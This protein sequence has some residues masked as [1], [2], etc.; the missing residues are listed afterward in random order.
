MRAVRKTTLLLLS[1]MLLVLAVAL[2]GCESHLTNEEGEHKTSLPFTI[3]KAD[4]FGVIDAKSWAT[5]FPNQYRTYMDNAKNK[6]PEGKADLL[7][8]YPEMVVN[9][10]GY[11]Y[12]KFFSEAGGHTY[13]LYTVTHNGRVGAKTKTGCIACKTPQFN[14]EAA[15]KGSK[16]YKEAFWPVVK[17]Y[18][19]PISCANC[20]DNEWPGKL[21]ITREQ[22]K[23]ALGDDADQ[24]TLSGEVCGQCHCDY[25]MDPYTAEPTS[26]YNG[27]STMTPD[28]ALAWYDQR[29]YTDWV[30]PSTGAKMIAVRHS[31]YEYNYGGKGNYMTSIGYDCVDCHMPNETAADGETYTSHYW[32]SPLENPTLIATNCKKCHK[33]LVAEVRY[34]QKDLDGRTHKIGERGADFIHNFE[35]ALKTGKLENDK[36]ARLRTIQREAIFYWNSVFAENSEGAHNPKLYTETLDRA[37]KLLN[38]GD[39]IL[40]KTSSAT[41]FEAWMKTQPAD[42]FK[43]KI[44]PEN[45]M[46]K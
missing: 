7:V 19:E 1:L 26:P 30:Y 27:V 21:K 36:V 31:E 6:W 24:H 25:S 44:A 11:G 43:S 3:P 37:E 33:D 34:L 40:G 20:H 9:G 35:A 4:Q 12:A 13:S 41:N 32:Q 15:K 46:P 18:T 39:K 22:W 45:M 16:I 8:E 23:T 14:A 42:T 29:N 38:E 10:T 28:Q 5:Q 17:K 2:S